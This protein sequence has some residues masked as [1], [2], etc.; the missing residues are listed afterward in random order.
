MRSQNLGTSDGP[1][2]S[3]AFLAGVAAVLYAASGSVAPAAAGYAGEAAVVVAVFVTTAALTALYVDRTLTP[4]FWIAAPAA[5]VALPATAAATSGY[6]VATSW[7]LGALAAAWALALGAALALVVERRVDL[8]MP[9]YGVGFVLTGT[10][11]AYLSFATL[12][13]LVAVFVGDAAAFALGG[14]VAAAASYVFLLLTEVDG[15]WTAAASASVVLVAVSAFAVAAVEPDVALAI[16]V[17]NVGF[18][19]GALPL[20][21]TGD[22]VDRISTA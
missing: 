9:A 22:F 1:E 13:L 2:R 7:T 14:V 11:L 6:V 17:V 4:G 8:R 20:T 10:V 12:G 18:F 3:I 21:S 16:T 19:A 5:A 15:K